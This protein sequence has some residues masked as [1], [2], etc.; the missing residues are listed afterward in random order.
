MVTTKAVFPLRMSWSI[1]LHTKIHAKKNKN[2]CI[3]TVGYDMIFHVTSKL[4]VFLDFRPLTA[5][6]N[7]IVL[8][9]FR[10][11]DPRRE[12][13]MRKYSYL[14]PADIIGIQSHYSEDEIDFHISE[15]NGILNIF[16]V[17]SFSFLFCSVMDLSICLLYFTNLI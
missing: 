9:W 10:R 15:F 12:C 2:I 4:Q 8:A 16:E 1:G 14:L 6:S 17:Y 13:N 3:W 11:F 5:I 7:F